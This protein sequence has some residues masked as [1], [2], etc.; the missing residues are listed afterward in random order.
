MS[1]TFDIKRFGMLFKKHTLEHGKTYLL[2]AGVLTGIMFL[3]LG[4]MSY[5]SNGHLRINEQ[6]PVFVFLSII[7]G[8]IFT[9]I[10]FTELGD[11]SKAIPTLMLPASHFE[12]YLVAWL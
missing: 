3:T 5:S 4:F 11:K 7:A 1:N 8:G 9:S 2:S 10:V 6:I 12:K